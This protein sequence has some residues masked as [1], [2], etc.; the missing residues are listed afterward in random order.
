MGA[1]IDVATLDFWGAQR[2]SSDVC[3][4]LFYEFYRQGL[5]D[6]LSTDYAGGHFD[7]PLVGVENAARVGAASLP[8]LIASGTS[9]VVDVFPELAPERG[10]VARDKIAD[11]VIT[12]PDSISDV[13]MVLVG[14]RIVVE[15]GSRV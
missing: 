5:V 9:R 1:I 6:L 4:E 10:L 7:N 12:D 8:A 2:L 15:D 3:Q 13:Q 11:L 14:G